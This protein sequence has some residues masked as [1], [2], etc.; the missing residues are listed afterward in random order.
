MGKWR[1]F[2]TSRHGKI[3][4]RSLALRVPS[5][6]QPESLTSK[7]ECQILKG[8]KMW[9]SKANL[10]V[11][12]CFKVCHSQNFVRHLSHLHQ[13]SQ[14][15]NIWKPQPATDL[16]PPMGTQGNKMEPSVSTQMR[17]GSSG[18]G[19]LQLHQVLVEKC[20]RHHKLPQL[21]STD[22]SS[23][24]FDAVH[25]HALWNLHLDPCG[26]CLFSWLYQVVPGTGRAGAEISKIGHDHRK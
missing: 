16:I 26:M 10:V 25:F 8:G 18:I 6:W 17:A 7:K 5:F 12:N 23:W 3:W 24:K 15:K 21:M 4:G 13:S 2:R 14:I 9:K 22:V 1:A 11:L 20:L 19:I